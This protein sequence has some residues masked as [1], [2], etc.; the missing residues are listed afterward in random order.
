MLSSRLRPGPPVNVCTTPGGAATKEPAPSQAL[1]VAEQEL[2]LAL[3]DVERV[4]VVVVGVRV[5]AFEARLELELDQ[6]ELVAADL[7]RRDPRLALEPLAFA[8][9]EEDRV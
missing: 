6:R 7:D 2:G 4:H 1:L 5:G 9:G 8:G 3:E